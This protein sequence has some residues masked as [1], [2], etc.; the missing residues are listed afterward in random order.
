VADE[1]EPVPPANEQP[2]Q[3][4]DGPQAPGNQVDAAPADADVA[5]QQLPEPGTWTFLFRV[6]LGYWLVTGWVVFSIIASFLSRIEGSS[7]S[8][9]PAVFT[10]PSLNPASLVAAAGADGVWIQNLD[11]AGP[12]V[13]WHLTLDYV[14]MLL[15]AIALWQVLSS[16]IGNSAYTVLVLG[17]P[18][19]YLVSDLIETIATQALLNCHFFGKGC[20]FGLSRNEAIA[21][22]V[23]TDLK[24]LALGANVLL[25]AVFYF[26][27]DVDGAVSWKRSR[28][29]RRV[30]RR[31]FHIAV[32]PP[33]GAYVILTVFAVLVA[34]PAGGPLDQMP[35]VLRAQLDELQHGEAQTFVFTLAA[36]ALMLL[37]L[38]GVVL[39]TVRVN[40]ALPRSPHTVAILLVG[41]VLTVAVGALHFWVEGAP[42]P[43]LAYAGVLLGV[44]GLGVLNAI[45]PDG[46][47][48]ENKDPEQPWKFEVRA[49][50]IGSTMIGGLVLLIAL[51]F[52]RATIPLFMVDGEGPRFDLW[53]MRLSVGAAILVPASAALGAFALLGWYQSPAAGPNRPDASCVLR[54]VVAGVTLALALALAG[55]P[56]TA[57]RFGTP[58][59]VMIGLSFWL[60]VVGAFGWLNRRV[61]WTYMTP[62]LGLRTPWMALLVVAWIVAGLL[63]TRSGYQDARTLDIPSAEATSPALSRTMDDAVTAWAS[64]WGEPALAGCT[65]QR[66]EQLSVPMVLVA[67]PGGGGKAA[68]WTAY[69]MDSIF[70]APASDSPREGT[71]ETVADKDQVEAVSFCPQNLFTAAG[72]SGGAIGLTTA[73]AGP[74]YD[75]PSGDGTDA[76]AEDWRDKAEA[77]QSLTQTAATRAARMTDQGPLSEALAAMLLRD[78]PQPLST[79]HGPWRDRAAVLEDAWAAAAGSVF[80]GETGKT[81]EKT[82]LTLGEGWWEGDT[83]QAHVGPVLLLSASSAGEGCRA[84]AAN[85]RGLVAAESSCLQ[86]ASTHTDEAQTGSVSGT[87]DVLDRLMPSLET[88]HDTTRNDPDDS[89]AADKVVGPA[90]TVRATTA[91]LLAARFPI[92][93]PS[94]AM[95]RCIKTSESDHQTS[96]VVDG[97]YLEN[98][99]IL[100]LLQSWHQVAGYVTG[101]NTQ[102]LMATGAAT[103]AFGQEPPKDVRSSLDPDRTIPCPTGSDGRLLSI[104]P[105]FVMLENHYR[106]TV[107]APPSPKRPRELLVPLTTL[108]KASTTLS[109]VPL[110]Q[111]VAYEV[112]Q[113]FPVNGT[114]VQLCNR[115]IRINPSLAAEVEAP[116]GWVLA[117]DT[118][119]GMRAALT[120][121]RVENLLVDRDEKTKVGS[122][123]KTVIDRCD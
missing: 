28:R 116:L 14:F 85:V 48:M 11:T 29:M 54:G 18:A 117:D 78:I 37:A 76:V 75:P 34:Y 44:A 89:C 83:D 77:E 10:K 13:G 53:A 81:N 52:V 87:V 31:S 7:A 90:Q 2:E 59:T 36:F 107:A 3:G 21:I 73:L 40:D 16:V 74:P 92:V 121:S 67:A 82:I 42:W 120:R 112:S 26:R 68:Y 115:F 114:A 35:D 24:W 15:V 39:P 119:F 96:Y 113:P 57:V 49:R 110:E 66:G 4:P 123:D 108:S 27:N 105:W 23:L 6:L 46:V 41:V 72:V 20:T 69:G 62:V 64:Q 12:L 60:G 95:R 101:C 9:G 111:A 47:Q 43:A 8:Y 33:A 93:T 22:N 56:Q 106:S 17:L 71:S 5:A 104:E 79:F 70:N 55:W 122:Y 118:R 103:G 58:A 50:V 97:G 84:L 100:T 86:A 102:A 99:G 109:Y 94:G 30:R 51:G 61:Q 32:G 25:I 38:V 88:K 80:D 91:A 63:D 98:T 45:L 1:G 19:A 65:T